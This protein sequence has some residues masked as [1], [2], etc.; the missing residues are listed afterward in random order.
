MTTVH[1]PARP[2]RIAFTLTEARRWAPIATVL[3]AFALTMLVVPVL[4]PVAIGD[5]WVY[6]RSVETLLASGELRILDLSVVTLVF[7]VAWGAVFGLLFGPGLGVLRLSTVIMTLIGGWACYGIAREL[8]V[9]RGKSALAAAAYLFNPLSFALSY[10]FMTDPHF[11]ALMTVSV[12]GYVRGLRPNG[13][14]RAALLLGAGAAALAFLVRQQGALVPAAVIAALLV[15]RRLRLDR[16]SL[17]LFLQVV[18]IPALALVAYYAWLFLIHGVPEQQGAFTERVTEAGW[19]ASALLVARMTF[20]AAMYLGLFGLPVVVGAL[21]ALPRVLQTQRPIGWAVTGAWLLMLVAGV[22][23]F[24]SLGFEPPPMPRMPYIPQYLGPSGLGPADLIGERPWLVSW[25]F[26]DLLTAVCAASSLLLVA[27]VARRFTA[28][29]GI[30][31]SRHAAMV[32]LLVLAGQVVGLFPPSFHFRDWIV[33]VDRYLLPL[34]PLTVCLGV[35]AVGQ[36]PWSRTG[37]WLVLTGF[38]LL[39]IAGTRDLL[40]FQQEVWKLAGEARRGGIPITRLDAGAAWDGYYL[41]EYS[42][43]RG[44]DQQTRGGPWWTDLFG[45]ATTS[46]YI[47]AS[48]PLEDYEVLARRPVSTWLAGQMPSV[49]LLRRDTDPEPP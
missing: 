3:A 48:I 24:D 40:V 8:G 6:A 11:T 17:L 38:A 36:L 15:Q 5:D 20:I 42:V 9:D 10:T 7:Q 29:T 44:L 45:P 22:R 4:A 14:S 46:D 21:G 27:L 25:Q 2:A 13:I 28:R 26:L 23:Y 47:V 16:A 30:D 37:A 18:A 32:V 12:Y 19:G 49:Y 31:P 35:W 34:L 1:Q 39:S 41:Y 33:S 43:A